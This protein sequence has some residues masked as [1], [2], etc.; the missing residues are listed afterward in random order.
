M[1]IYSALSSEIPII[2]YSVLH[3]HKKNV[4]PKEYIKSLQA[5]RSALKEETNQIKV[6]WENHI[7]DITATIVQ[8]TRGNLSQFLSTPLQSDTGEIH[9]II[10]EQV[11]QTSS[12]LLP[13]IH[14]GLLGGFDSKYLVETPQGDIPKSRLVN[15]R[16]FLQKLGFKLGKNNAGIFESIYIV[17]GGTNLDLLEHIVRKEIGIYESAHGKNIVE[18]AAMTCALH[19]L[20]FLDGT[21]EQDGDRF[22]LQVNLVKGKEQYHIF[23]KELLESMKYFRI[24]IHNLNVSVW[25]RKLGLGVGE[26]YILRVRAK[27]RSTLRSGITSIQK[28]IQNRNHLSDALDTATWLV[29]EFV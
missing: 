2:A 9:R 12:Q 15:G 5:F 1:S 8:T 7:S 20:I 18:M 16:A 24:E 19:N 21:L 3:Q 11:I 6:V 27:D 10:K 4:A 29:K 13:N 25:Q 14:F 23:H 17:E 26:E 28:F 22:E